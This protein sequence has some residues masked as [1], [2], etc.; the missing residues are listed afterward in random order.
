MAV[1]EPPSDSPDPDDWPDY[2]P[3]HDS[4]DWPGSPEE[5]IADLLRQAGIPV[6]A[7][8]S[9]EQMLSQLAHQ[10]VSQLQDQAKT[11]GAEP[12]RPVTWTAAKQA[13]RT[14]IASLGP[15][16]VPDGRKTREIADAVHL[17]ELWLD[18]HTAF[19][20][21][22]LPPA[23]WSRAEWIEQTLPAWQTMIEPVISTIA[24]GLET[25][26]ADRL[27]QPDAVPELA[28]FQQFLQPVLRQAAD[29][30]FGARL[31]KELG[32]IATETVTAT[33]LGFPLLA[34]PQVAVLPTN[35]AAFA[36]GLS[37]EEGDILLYHS[38]REAAR[39]RL[40]AEVS[41]IGPQ[42]TALV[43]HY[44]REIR[45]DP[46]ALSAAIEES[47]P[48]EITRETVD[49]FEVEVNTFIFEP[50][51]TPEQVAIL[52]RLETALAL[53]EGWVDDVAVQ[54]TASWMPSAGAVAEMIRRR[55]VTNSPAAA[56]FS[57]LLGLNV[58][59]K[60]FREA[61]VFWAQLR[62]ARGPAGR[63]ETWRHP[64]DLPTAAE[65]ADPAAFLARLDSPAGAV[66]D[67][68]DIELRRLLD[69]G[70]E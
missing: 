61:Q 32:R 49:R 56:V 45:I 62:A 7:G 50:G 33:D 58:R 16:P 36:D 37:L 40:F 46:E 26:M 68:F 10:I 55:R 60:L 59:P 6:E 70:E 69:G 13:A 23:A 44:A 48:H 54:A 19:P 18:A 14:Q 24:Q 28:Q 12:D 39:Q 15:D 34:K 25:A 1:P 5:G 31:G 4:E 53:L 22:A 8:A 35:L 52:E 9:L 27:R 38:I 47:V 67:P 21:L 17:V 43:Q 42:I 2:D 11:S 65:L 64:D 51:K 3:D 20:S 29:S 66:L 63:D 57:T 30:M 41:W